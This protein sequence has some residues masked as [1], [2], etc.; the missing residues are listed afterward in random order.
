[1]R[2]NAPIA[3]LLLTIGLALPPAH[4]DSGKP[5]CVGVADAKSKSRPYFKGQT[6]MTNLLALE[7]QGE[8]K[9]HPTYAPPASECLFEK[10]EVAAVPVEA[11]YSPFEKGE[12]TLHWRFT[13]DGAEPRE[14]L[15][16]YDGMASFMAKKDISVFFVVEERKGNISYYAMYR[17]QPT[18]ALLKPLVSGILD[19]SAQPLATV[20]W[21]KGEKEPV[22]NAYDTKRLK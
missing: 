8:A 16:L 3:A 2:T 7:A 22:I 17:D 19:G 13:A 18:Y 10:F 5:A 21:P 15:V 9:F 4:A 14:V 20:N 1:M 11:I 6:L 12:Y